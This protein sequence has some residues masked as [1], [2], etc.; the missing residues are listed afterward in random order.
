MVLRSGLERLDLNDNEV[1]TFDQVDCTVHISIEYHECLY[2]D[3]V[4]QKLSLP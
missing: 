2:L 1:H 3:Q 4:R